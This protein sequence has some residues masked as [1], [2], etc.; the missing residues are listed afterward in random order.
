MHLLTY[1]VDGD[2]TPRLGA[3]IGADRVA[4]L[5]ALASA[6]GVQLP[7]SVLE[8]IRAGE[9]A[10]GLMFLILYHRFFLQ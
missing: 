2:E 5:T 8:L 7:G 1:C 3:R 4:D 10:L 6:A 9:P